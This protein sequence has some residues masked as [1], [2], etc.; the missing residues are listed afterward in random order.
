MGLTTS[1]LSPVPLTCYTNLS[2]NFSFLTG[3][4]R[5]FLSQACSIHIDRPECASQ[6]FIDLFLEQNWPATN[7]PCIQD[8]IDTTTYA[9]VLDTSRMLFNPTHF[10]PSKTCLKKLYLLIPLHVHMITHTYTHWK[11]EWVTNM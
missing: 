11:E 9:R 5:H 8:H 7:E 4:N 3:Y 2:L 1:L 6:L 10:H